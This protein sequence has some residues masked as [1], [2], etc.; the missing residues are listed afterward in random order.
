MRHQTNRGQNRWVEPGGGPML[1]EYRVII[2][3]AD[4]WSGEGLTGTFQN[5]LRRQSLINNTCILNEANQTAAKQARTAY[6]W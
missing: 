3:N 2:A 4:D 5:L 1:P 6:G